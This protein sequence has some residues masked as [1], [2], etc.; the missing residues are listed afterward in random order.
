VALSAA[1]VTRKGS[2]AYPD[3]S[4]VRLLPT[5]ALVVTLRRKTDFAK[6]CDDIGLC[7]I[8]SPHRY[9][10][11]PWRKHFAHL[12]YGHAYILQSVEQVACIGAPN[13]E[14]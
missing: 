14:Q 13:A 1:Q 11:F 5:N 12:H 3:E 9:Q 8:S 6:L 2:K 7:F 10:Q 4:L